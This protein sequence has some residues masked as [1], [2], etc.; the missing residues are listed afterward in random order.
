MKKDDVKPESKNF[1]DI[2]DSL[3]LYEIPRF[4]RPFAWDQENAEK[5]YNDILPYI[6]W[7][8]PDDGYFLWSIVVNKKWDN[9]YEV[10]DGQQR[11]TVSSI[12]L[13]AIY[14]L[15]YQI[16][17]Q[18]AILRIYKYLRNWDLWGAP[19]NV[20]TLSRNN[21]E[22]YCSLLDKNIEQ[23]RLI[24]KNS[25]S[26]SNKKLLTILQYFIQKLS[27]GKQQDSSLEKKRIENVFNL[28][29]KQIFVIQIPVSNY[30]EGSKIFEV[31]NNRWQDLT[32]AD[33]VR[34]YLFSKAEQEGFL[35]SIEKQWN[36]LE[37]DIWVD[38]LEQFFRYSSFGFSKKDD[39][40]ERVEEAVES[41]SSI[42][43]I[44]KVAHLSKFYNCFLNPW[45]AED[46][47]ETKLLEEMRILGVTQCYSLLLTVHDKFW[48]DVYKELLEYIINFTFIYSTI[49]W[50][51]PNKIEK[52]Y[53]LLSFE[54]NFWFEKD[55]EHYAHSLDSIKSRLKEVLP[56]KLIFEQRFR[57]KLFKTNKI[58]R[59][60][61]WKIEH[62]IST[63]EKLIN[64]TEVHLEHVMPQNIDIWNWE[65][66]KYAPLHKKY[67]YCLGNMIL[68]SKKLNT[69][70]KNKLFVDKKNKYL[71]KET[72]LNIIKLMDFGSIDSWDEAQ[73]NNNLNR[74]L[75]HAKE[76]WWTIL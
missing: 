5:F 48:L 58:P 69:S 14:L 21:D 20:L 61:I 71:E 33:L 54:V 8:I 67:V 51:N 23:I 30:K 16:H 29:R 70:I 28:F 4:Q 10:I 73:I 34:N 57:E 41:S 49:C 12:F 36:K 7:T 37:D 53:S 40:F 26:A 44:G 2:F 63:N 52:I 42:T 1:H 50:E 60:L 11:L 65:D 15:Y 3:V 18:D 64:P 27:E 35:D 6:D 74:Y 46:D 32:K 55:G 72:Q 24:E 47:L 45:L 62:Y 56:S 17:Q 38:S 31:L 76:I 25:L 39:I 75:D 43:F 9:L 19:K 68:L 66:K 13:F 59:Y 22:F